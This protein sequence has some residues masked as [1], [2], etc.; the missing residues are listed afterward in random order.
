MAGRPSSAR[1]RLT[2]VVMSRR[3]SIRVPSRSKTRAAGRSIRSRSLDLNKF[4][5]DPPRQDARLVAAVH[6]ELH[7]AAAGL[8]VIAGPVVDV[9]ADEAVRA[10]RVVLQAAGV[11]GGVAERLL[12]V[13]Q[14]IVDALRQQPAEAA[15][16]V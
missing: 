1:I 14:T 8:A 6:Q 2:A 15:L 5:L 4:G 16:E 3:E 10:H 9:H 13:I 12:P 7:G 11:A